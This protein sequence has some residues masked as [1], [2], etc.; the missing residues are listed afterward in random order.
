[1]NNST[2]VAS[3]DTPE[4][5]LP[6]QPAGQASA[7]HRGRGRTSIHVDPIVSGPRGVQ[8]VAHGRGLAAR[9]LWV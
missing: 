1:M 4:T 9:L 7:G 8:D 2:I 3:A 5:R 6:G